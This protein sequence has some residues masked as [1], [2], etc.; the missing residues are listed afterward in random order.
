V[1]G[2]NLVIVVPTIR[3]HRIAPT[4]ESAKAA[5]PDARVLFVVD[6]DDTATQQAV[7]AVASGPGAVGG[8]HTHL[9]STD[10]V[11]LLLC[12]GGW[13]KKINAGIAA[14]TEPLIFTGAD[15]LDF[16]EGW[17]EA[18]APRIQD[19]AEAGGRNGCI[20][21]VGTNDL[22]N[23]RVMAGKHATHFLVARWYAEWGTVDEPG[24]LLH[25]GYEVEFSD[26]ELIATAK[27]RGCWAM[28][29]DAEV[30]HLH[31]VWGKG[32]EKAQDD[33]SYNR[34][35]DRMA[36]GRAIFNSRKPLWA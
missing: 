13:P 11:D 5:T 24:K 30:E 16:R 4:L 33:P 27:V 14:S 10:G 22:G 8:P 36:R 6:H 32:D 18:A 31:P 1:S 15:D 2:E 19:P 35:K 17:F 28:A 29:L 7:Q 12:D 26:D 34:I 23:P 21:V 20:G 9:L 25:E 3:P